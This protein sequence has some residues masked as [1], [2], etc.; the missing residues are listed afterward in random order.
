MIAPL[1]TGL[2]ITSSYIFFLIL[3]IWIRRLEREQFQ[4]QLERVVPKRVVERDNSGKRVDR[5]EWR[6][7]RFRRL[8]REGSGG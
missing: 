8:E 1:G 2:L 5:R 4:S 7:K 6:E 3:W